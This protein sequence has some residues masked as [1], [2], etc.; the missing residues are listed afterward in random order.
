[1]N[2]NSKKVGDAT[3]DFAQKYAGKVPKVLAVN[4]VSGGIRDMIELSRRFEMKLT[5]NFIA[6]MWSLSGHTVSLNIASCVRELAEQLKE[7]WDCIVISG[8]VWGCLSK[9]VIAAV[10]A[11]VSNGAGLIV[12]A[13]EELPTELKNLIKQRRSPGKVQPWSVAGNSALLAGVPF[14]AL[15][16]TPVFTYQ[17]KGG[18]VLANAGNAPLVTEF[19]LG[20]GKVFVC[21][22]QVVK[23]RKSKYN[24]SSN[25]FLP[26]LNDKENFATCEWRLGAPPQDPASL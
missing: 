23:A 9:D 25:F 11:K 14:A 4:S 22:W 8:D 24:R 6:G 1:M 12:T 26:F 3:F 20:K 21:A 10:L 13:P 18:K 5:T 16:P 7:N 19:S 2:F 15:P 17:I